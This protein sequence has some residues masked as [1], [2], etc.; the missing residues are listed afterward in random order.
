MKIQRVL[1][2]GLHPS[3]VDYSRW[4]GLTA[5]KLQAAIDHSGDELKQLGYAPEVCLFDL[6]RPAEAVLQEKLSQVAYDCVM[7]GAGV[8]TDKEHFFMF[9]KLVNAVHQYAPQARICFNTGPFDT[10]AAFQRWA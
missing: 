10:A 1:I 8:R 6:K 9:E 3:A 4:P 2:T 7:I 5:E